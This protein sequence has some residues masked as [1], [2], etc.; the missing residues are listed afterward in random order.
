MTLR[1][2]KQLEG[3]KE[4][5]ND[6]ALHNKNEHV[7]NVEKEMSSPSTEVID[8]VMHKPDEVPKDSNIISPKLYTP[9]LPFP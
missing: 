9:P 1:G 6:E 7:K 3:P 5:T 8:D 2:G 4:V